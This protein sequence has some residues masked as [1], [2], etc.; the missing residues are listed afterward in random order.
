M[1]LNLDFE[2]SDDILALFK[3]DDG[4]KKTEA[5]VSAPVPERLAPVAK[6]RK[7]HRADGR[8][9][10]YGSVTLKIQGLEPLVEGVMKATYQ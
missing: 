7:P 5:K 10:K 1:A 8:S 9:S 3:K 2:S 6:H 4:A